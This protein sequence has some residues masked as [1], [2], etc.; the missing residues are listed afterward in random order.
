[1]KG[2]E[3]NSLPSRA[4]T[5]SAELDQ[6]ASGFFFLP[7][8]YRLIGPQFSGLIRIRQDQNL[9][10]FLPLRR[11]RRIRASFGNLPVTI[12]IIRPPWQSEAESPRGS[13]GGPAGGIVKRL[14]I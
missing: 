10:S 12:T 14:F 6:F 2:T 1:M 11:I 5:F 8:E 13:T 9:P 4:S 7:T 3:G